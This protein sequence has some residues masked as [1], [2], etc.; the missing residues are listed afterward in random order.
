MAALR[1]L[2]PMAEG[3]GRRIALI[4]GEAG[5]G[6]SRLVREFANSA[7]EDGALVLYGAC[8]AVV[9]G[10]YQPITEALEQFV[11]SADPQ[12]LRDDL[13]AGGGELTRLVPSLSER[14]GGLPP[15]VAAD[16]DTERLRLHH[17]VADLLVN[18]GARRPVVL[19]LEDAHWADGPTL[20]LLRHLSRAAAAARLLLIVTFRDTAAEIPSDL[21]AALVELRRS[22]GVVPIR[23]G[24]LSVEE[25]SELVARA[26]GGAL[27]DQ[28]PVVA[29]EVHELTEGNPFLVI[30]LWRELVESGALVVVDG[31]ARLSRP[32]AEVA[33]PEAVREVVSQRL[34]RLDPVT[35]S[36]LQLA[37]VVGPDFDL[38]LIRV[39]AGGD[40]SSLLAA[41]DLA[42]QSG[43]ISTVPERPLRYRFSHEL[44][45]RALYDRLSG[46]RRA[47]L[48]L[49]AAEALERSQSGSP[50]ELAHHFTEAA[51]LGG[52]D[53]AIDYNLRA[54]AAANSALAFDQA[55]ESLLRALRLGV[56]NP[57]R[58]AQIRFDLGE[59]YFRAGQS[60]GALD[61]YLEV[62]EI[63]RELEDGELFAN[64]AI[65]F[66]N[67]C[68]RMGA[69]DVEALDLLTEASSR[70]DPRDS[71][72]RVMVLSGTARAYAFRGDHLRSAEFRGQ[73]VAMARRLDD[74][75]ALAKVT[76][77]AYWARGTSSL[78]EI[79]EML[80]ESLRL[81]DEL[82]DI[83]TQ[84]EAREWRI[85]AL[86]AKGDIETAR[87]ELAVVYEV[88]S[89]MGQPFIL[90]VA[91][92]YRATIEL[93]DGRLSEAEAAAGR[94][95]EWGNLLT[96]RDSTGPYGVQM[97]SIRREQ[98]RLA[99]L[100]PVVRILSSGDRE[101]GAWGPGLAALLAE[102]GMWDDA[103]AE[104]EEIRLRGL[105]ELRPALWL[106][107]LTYLTDA[108][109][110]V[111]DAR[112]AGE[113]Y[114]ALEPYAGGIVAVGHGVV[115]YG[116]VDRYLGMAAA[117]AG[118]ADAARAHFE[119]A[120]EVNS[121]M[122]ARTWLAHTAYTYGRLLL[123]E[124]RV[125]AHEL[126]RTASTL[127]SQ[128]GMPTLI[129]RI[130]A[131]GA[132]I[133]ASPLPDD[134]SPREVQI[135]GQVAQGL[136]NREIGEAM[137]ISQ[138][139]VANHVRSILRKTGSANRTEAGAYAHQHGLAPGR[140]RE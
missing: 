121:R 44:V 97:F 66:E 136:S 85:A 86:I 116:S 135:L 57:Q 134:L 103:R 131:A 1:S 64:A 91:E 15:P 33:S 30:E 109:Y 79:L 81:A 78:D 114:A 3:E 68:W 104:L 5:S 100:A 40:E 110:A 130:A 126:L 87:R 80:D 2:M 88:A 9:S 16:Q 90:H 94:S 77:R 62:A 47:E 27:G 13:G 99:E 125:R 138:H 120:M 98:G 50:A 124:D 115:C 82:G 92:H 129:A 52:A 65:G 14:V 12:E 38:A 132:P 63:A 69:V 4:G 56:P 105:D 24:G 89:R 75:A 10:P 140:R 22:E 83:E 49:R 107:S 58:Q 31:T 19:V 53:R 48:H 46:L 34:D 137:M 42:E 108:S 39:G 119:V 74:R 95:F 35:T 117:T 51:S 61:A 123:P 6:K 128:V 67:A 54:A 43:M 122:N 17:A 32:L 72:L 112:M 113:L 20:F 71:S 45:R 96:G 18:I 101:G 23:L 60:N 70:L 84:A 7:A 21:S 41:V 36:V 93:C 28:L 25:I 102:L 73:A 55:A 127:A 76:M 139:T 111:G 59:A 29:G 118:D 133:T 37:A 8:D 106:A 11:R 26:G